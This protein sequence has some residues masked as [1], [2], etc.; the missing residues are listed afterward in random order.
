MCPTVLLLLRVFYAAG[1]CLPNPCLATIGGSHIQTHRLMGA[2]YEVQRWDGLRCHDVHTQFRKDWLRHWDANGWTHRH[3]D[4]WER[5]MRHAV[6]MGSGALMYIPS[7]IKI[8]WGIHKLMGGHTQTHRLMG[9]IY[10]ACRWDGFRCHDVHTKFRKD[11]FSHSDVKGGHTD[12]QSDG[13]DLW[14]MPLRWAQ[15]PWCTYQVS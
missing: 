2:I 8:G 12:T 11:W 15:V 10:E 14:S 7:F 4:W 13:R 1:T 9:G 6:E 3:T 5:F